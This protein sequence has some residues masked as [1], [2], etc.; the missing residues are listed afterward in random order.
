MSPAAPMGCMAVSACMD[1]PVAPIGWPLA[2]SPPDGLTGKEP[3]FS[4]RPSATARAPCPSGTRP[5]AS[6][7]I[8]SAMVKQSWVSTKER[9]ESAMPALASARAAGGRVQGRGPPARLDQVAFHR[10]KDAPPGRGRG[11]GTRLAEL[12]RRCDASQTD[13]GG[14]V[15]NEGAVRAL[16]RPRHARI[17]FALGAA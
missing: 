13:G 9:L 7:S 1:T 12:E 8:S 2:L 3:S 14:A 16:G 17:L 11:E 6:Y 10:G 5:I 15:G 4:V